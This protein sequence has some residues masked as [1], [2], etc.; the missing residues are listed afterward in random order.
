MMVSGLGSRKG[1]ARSKDAGGQ[2][3]NSLSSEKEESNGQQLEGLTYGPGRLLLVIFS[4]SFY[5]FILI[6]W[7]RHAAYKIEP[8]PPALEAQSLN[9]WTAR[10]V[11]I[12]YYYFFKGFE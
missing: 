5:L 8:A 1:G 3:T 4:F 10:E 2:S 7:L 9:P 11:P 6:F 12:G